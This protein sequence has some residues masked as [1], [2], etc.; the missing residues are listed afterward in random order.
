MITLPSK[1]KKTQTE[2][3]DKPLAERVMERIAP[4]V[5]EQ[6]RILTHLR[7][8]LEANDP[9]PIYQELVDLT[10]PENRHIDVTGLDP[11]AAAEVRLAHEG[12]VIARRGELSAE[13]QRRTT[14]YPLVRSELDKARSMADH[15]TYQ[16]MQAAIVT[17][18]EG[19]PDELAAHL[20]AILDELDEMHVAHAELGR[21]YKFSIVDRTRL[22][23][24]ETLR[25]DVEKLLARIGDLTGEHSRSEAS[26]VY[27]KRIRARK[28]GR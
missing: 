9:D 17:E 5:D 13:R 4:V 22:G 27:V 16:A 3:V 24:F 23:T 14:L 21:H 12:K 2:A 18:T 11:I 26:D 25:R 6:E 19:T 10:D 1:P 20:H 7:G 8:K 28:G 15:R